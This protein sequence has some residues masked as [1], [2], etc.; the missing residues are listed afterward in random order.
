MLDNATGLDVMM[1]IY[2]LIQCSDNYA[3]KCITVPQVRAEC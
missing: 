1:L 3:W 2:N